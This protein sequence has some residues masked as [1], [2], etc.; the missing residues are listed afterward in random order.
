VAAGAGPGRT[1][2]RRRPPHIAATR[3]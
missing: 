1:P 2:A 3:P